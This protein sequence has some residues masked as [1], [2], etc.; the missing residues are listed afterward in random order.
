MNRP[1]SGAQCVTVPDSLLS[2]PAVDVDEV[3]LLPLVVPVVEDVFPSPATVPRSG[4]RC[5]VDGVA[6]AADPSDGGKEGP[7]SAE[8]VFGN[9]APSLNVG[10]L[11][12]VRGGMSSCTTEPPVS[13]PFLPE[14]PI[15]ADPVGLLSIDLLGCDLA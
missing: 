13:K 7:F 4:W 11:V 9:T 12:S 3:T 2:S 10:A 15:A 6:C 14:P 1:C 8:G 5:C